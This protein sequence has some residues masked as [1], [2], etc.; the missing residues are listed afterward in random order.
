ML[1]AS[2]QSTDP[3]DSLIRQSLRALDEEGRIPPREGFQ[4][5][6]K[7]GL[8][9]KKGKLDQS[10]VQCTTLGELNT[11]ATIAKRSRKSRGR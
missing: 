9:D 10:H 1:R 7:D 11:L 3:V 6:V 5:L 8:I 2:I 4:R